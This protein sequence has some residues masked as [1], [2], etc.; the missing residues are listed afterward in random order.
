MNA[1]R[2]ELENDEFE[3]IQADTDEE[4]IKRALEEYELVFNIVLLD[5][6]YDEVKTIY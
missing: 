2:V 5:K 4:A 1:Y 3:I 6:D